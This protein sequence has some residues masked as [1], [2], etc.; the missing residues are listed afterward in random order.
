MKGKEI[1]W[2]APQ[3]RPPSFGGMP[4]E[5]KA[6]P[7]VEQFFYKQKFPA[8]AYSQELNDDVIERF[9]LKLVGHGYLS[10]ECSDDGPE[11]ILKV[12]AK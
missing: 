10:V 6:L 4:R 11:L 8:L 5:P 7:I 9:D 1:Y 2:Y 12:K 3:L